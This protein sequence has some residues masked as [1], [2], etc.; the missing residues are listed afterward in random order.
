MFKY[1]CYTEVMTRTYAVW[2][3][4]QITNVYI[5][6]GHNSDKVEDTIKSP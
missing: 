3:L 1:I 5:L 4:L 2:S 6:I